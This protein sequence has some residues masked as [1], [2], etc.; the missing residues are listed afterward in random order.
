MAAHTIKKE[1]VTISDV[2]DNDNDGIIV[3]KA[4]MLVKDEVNK[5]TS[6][7][8]FPGMLLNHENFNEAEEY[9]ETQAVKDEPVKNNTKI[10]GIVIKPENYQDWVDTQ[11]G[12]AKDKKA[13]SCKRKISN[14]GEEE[15][16]NKYDSFVDLVAEEEYEES[17]IQLSMQ[18]AKLALEHE[19]VCAQDDLPSKLVKDMMSRMRPKTAVKFS[20]PMKNYDIIVVDKFDWSG[21]KDLYS[22]FSHELYRVCTHNMFTDTLVDA[23][24]RYQLNLLPEGTTDD[25]CVLPGQFFGLITHNWE[26]NVMDFL[27]VKRWMAKIDVFAK[28]NMAFSIY[29]S[30]HFTGFVFANVHLLKNDLDNIG[31]NDAIPVAMHGD[32]LSSYHDAAVVFDTMKR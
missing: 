15:K 4:N 20:D 2:V 23:L 1:Y 8:V 7:C 14:A 26:K 11:I 13:N 28:N 31:N 22:I 24:I 6:S 16:S 27:A 19:T 25:V 17:T 29:G 18:L 12:Q 21:A 3:I 32:S 5:N 9:T 30:M 10:S